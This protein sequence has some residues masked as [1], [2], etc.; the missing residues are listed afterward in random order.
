MTGRVGCG[1][2]MD[3]Y[4]S[5]SARSPVGVVVILGAAVGLVWQ[6][7]GVLS[8]ALLRRLWRGRVTD[9]AAR[10]LPGRPEARFRYHVMVPNIVRGGVEAPLDH[11]LR[12]RG[13]DVARP[14]PAA[15]D[16]RAG[17]LLS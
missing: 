12:R 7:R 13:T 17:C 3:V 4:A 9:R 16:T 8:G 6:E 2:A 15:G 11:L 5:G 14:S 1:A 10:R